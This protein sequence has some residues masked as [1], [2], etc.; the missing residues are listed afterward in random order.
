MG[1]NFG[2][3]GFLTCFGGPEFA[4]AAKALATGDYRVDE[5]TLL[6]G[7]I[8]RKGK[9]VC[10]QLGL[11]DVVVSRSERSRLIR[12]D[13]FIDETHLTEYNADGLVIATSTGSTAYSL[14]AGGPIVMPESAVFV[15]TPI[16][17][18]VLTNRSVIVPHRSLIRLQLSRPAQR[19]SVCID[20]HEPVHIQSGDVVIV[21]AAREKLPLL[22]PKNLTFAD[23]LGTKLRWSGSAI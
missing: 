11:N 13:V 22:L 23:I 14:S 17:P 19:L 4:V 7:S 1:I 21:Q 8:E 9:T 20:G 10:S 16:C 6:Q 12:M 15:V 3:L 5:R 2:S 18:H